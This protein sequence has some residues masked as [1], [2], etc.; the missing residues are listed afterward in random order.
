MLTVNGDLVTLF[1]GFVG[2]A[3]NSFLP[4]LASVI[5]LFLAFAVA[6]RLRFLIPR[7]LKK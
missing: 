5:G 2:Q 7:M 6:D 4:L 1:S 3:M